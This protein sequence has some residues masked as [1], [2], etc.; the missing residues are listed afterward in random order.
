MS[1]AATL[2][3]DA[4][5]SERLERMI[6]VDH[7][8]EYGAVRIYQ[9][10]LA[11]L[12]RGKKGNIL[13]HMLE[14]EV[15]HEKT[16]AGLI[17]DR[18]VRPTALLP[19]WHLAGFALGAV[20]A[21]I[22]EPRAAMPRSRTDRLLLSATRDRGAQARVQSAPGGGSLATTAGQRGWSALPGTRN[23]DPPPLSVVRAVQAGTGNPV[24]PADDLR[25]PSAKFYSAAAALSRSMRV[26][27]SGLSTASGRDI[28]DA[29]WVR[30]LTPALR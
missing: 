27:R 10:Q 8:G 21:A 3:G 16:F 30:L 20:S 23:F 25:E 15:V 12:G 17:A 14:Q 28:S 4:T 13:R 1:H 19:L 26:L 2:P 22:G 5:P 18:R 7:A 11:V 24:R 6:R 29:S 9:G